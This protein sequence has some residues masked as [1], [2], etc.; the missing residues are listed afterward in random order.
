MVTRK[1]RTSAGWL[2][3]FL[4]LACAAVVSSA[5]VHG[6]GGAAGD[7]GEND[8]RRPGLLQ[9][10][11][12]RPYLSFGFRN[13]L[14]DIVWLQAVQTAGSRRMAREDY[15]RLYQLVQ[16]VANFDPRFVVPYILGGLIL[17]DSPHHTQEAIRTLQRGYE[18]H[19]SDW[20][21]PFYIG[22][23]E[24]FSLGNPEEGGKSLQE[25]SKLPNSPP[26]LPFLAS[27]MLSEGRKPEIALDFIRTMIRQETDPARREI[28]NRRAREVVVERDLQ[29]LEEAVAKY[30]AREG[31][32]PGSLTD[33][34]RAGLIRAVPPEPNGGR[35]LLDAGGSVRSDRVA[36][37]LKVFRFQ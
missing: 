2:V 35:Y 28:L 10:I 18:N 29:I 36:R 13:L 31:R 37:R 33:L 11:S 32:T 19:P 22:Y 30:R 24:Y 15:D 34:L 21:F 5:M 4:L 17:G 23:T 6:S 8:G 26:H 12:Y 14:A 3:P 7:R 9:V 25:A 27:R 16:A 1:A 20:R